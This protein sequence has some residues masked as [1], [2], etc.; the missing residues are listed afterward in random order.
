M[1]ESDPFQDQADGVASLQDAME[2]LEAIAQGTTSRLI[3]YPEALTFISAISGFLEDFNEAEDMTPAELR[4]LCIVVYE[5][6]FY[7]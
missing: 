5:S 1:I 6:L 4:R 7:E 3:A 2:F